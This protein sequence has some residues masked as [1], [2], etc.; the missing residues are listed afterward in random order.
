M[1]DGYDVGRKV[2]DELFVVGPA[3]EEVDIVSD[4]FKF[5]FVVQATY[6]ED[7]TK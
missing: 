2:V 1:K 3:D 5:D 4:E 7:F 6:T